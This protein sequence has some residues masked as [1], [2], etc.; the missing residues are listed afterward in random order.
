MSR[1]GRI[2]I[3]LIAKNTSAAVISEISSDNKATL[4]E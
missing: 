4:R 3:Q 1:T 2:M